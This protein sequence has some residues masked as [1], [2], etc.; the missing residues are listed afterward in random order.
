MLRLAFLCFSLAAVAAAQT[1][2][3]IITGIVTDGSG[4]AV[5]G[6]QVNATNQA[7]GLVFKA[8]SNDAGVYVVPALPIRRY[9]VDMTH[10]GCQGQRFPGLAVSAGARAKLDVVLKVGTVNEVV[11]VESELPVLEAETSSLGQVIE[12]TPI[13]QMPLNGRNYQRLAVL[14]PGVLPSRS[15]NFVDDSFSVNGANMFQN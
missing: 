6:A 4:A 3:A 2:T 10:Q 8:V 13:T 5:P 11:E 12:N 14:S 1:D 15:R 9:D 7:T